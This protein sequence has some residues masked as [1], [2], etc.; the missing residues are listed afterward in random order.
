M[1]LSG[2]VFE[3]CVRV[4]NRNIR[5]PTSTVNCP[6]APLGSQDTQNPRSGLFPLQRLSSAIKFSLQTGQ[7]ALVAAC[8]ILFIT[9]LT[10]VNAQTL[11]ARITITSVAPARIRITA[12]VPSAVNVLSFRNTYGGVLGLGER[13]EKVEAR[14]ATDEVVAVRKLAPGEFQASEKF[15]RFSYDVNVTEPARP[16]QMSHVSWL[17]RQHGLLMLADL[18]PQSTN[19]FVNFHT[20]VIQ[21]EL[22][23]GWISTSNVKNDGVRYSTDHPEK[24]VFLIGPALQEKTR[25]I[26]S[27]TFSLIASGKWP[28]SDDEAIK[29]AGKI[30]EGYSKVTGFGIKRSAVLMLI[31]YPGEARPERWSAETR[32]DAVVLLLGR[33]ASNKEALRMLGIVLSHELFHLWVPNSLK[34][35]G[36]YD[37]FFEGF[38]LYQALRMDLR[39]GLISFEDFLATIARVYDSYLTSPERDTLSLVG[40]SERRWT[41][42]S[43]L[44]YDKGTLVAFIYDLMLRSH[45]DC[46]ASLDTVYKELFKQKATGHGSAT[47]TI[48]KLL[49][50]Q[51]GMESFA[52]VYV[53]GTD[54]INLDTFLPSYGFHVQ[55]GSHV[56]KATRLAVVQD[57]SKTQ[58]RL[59]GCLGYKK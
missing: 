11:R 20:A 17:N 10:N 37:W 24:A 21:F 16:A 49:T 40:A 25:R 58:R 42:S 7:G 54:K 14:K 2:H 33:G 19:E 9:S 36:D 8:A 59:L 35:E 3:Q 6:T 43:S 56:N 44:V 28:F 52:R 34:L 41:T 39:L 46:K 22:P 18:L 51:P 53:E 1:S 55:R 38:T 30:I 29:M 23:E 32:D 31:P 45:S 13:I 5:M 12:E 27:T 4:L 57:L 15:T 48:I 26:G 50:A 47:E